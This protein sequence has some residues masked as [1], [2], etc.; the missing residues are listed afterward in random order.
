MAHARRV[1]L[2]LSAGLAAGGAISVFFDAPEWAAVSLVPA[3]L[4]GV[5][6][7]LVPARTAARPLFAASLNLAIGTAHCV[8]VMGMFIYWPLVLV[9]LVGYF[10]AVWPKSARSILA[11][12]FGTIGLA[13]AALAM[14][15]SLYDHL[16]A[17]LRG[18]VVPIE[19]HELVVSLLA[20][21]V[22]ALCFAFAHRGGPEGPTLRERYAI[23]LA[24][25]AVVPLTA[26]AYVVLVKLGL[27][28]DA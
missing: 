20:G 13:Y 28:L 19:A 11:A 14:T 25:F 22:G 18:E 26:V 9:G 4:V 6:A 24:A 7:W 21:I 16:L 1:E 5:V 15:F 12:L 8:S 10:L 23:F 3:L 2:G 17:T 27:P